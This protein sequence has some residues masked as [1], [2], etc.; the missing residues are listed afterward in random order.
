MEQ[1][2]SA[3]GLLALLGLAFAFS[4]NHRAVNLRTLVWGMS[5][6][7]LFAVIILKEGMA[8][9]TGMFVLIFLIVLFIFEDELAVI[10]G[11]PAGVGI[12]SFVAAAAGVGIFY[13][14]APFGTTAYVLAVVALS[15]SLRSSFADGSWSASRS[16]L[17]S[18]AGASSRCSSRGWVC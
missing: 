9:F 4:N 13:Y 15:G 10:T 11:H 6:Q 2:I 8:S 7:M 1:V 3:V 14:L 17:I 16:C 5:L 12:G 18:R